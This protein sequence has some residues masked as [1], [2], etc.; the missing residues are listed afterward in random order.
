MSRLGVRKRGRRAQGLA[1]SGWG[2]EVWC[3]D[4]AMGASVGA[5]H[6]PACSFEKQT[7]EDNDD[8]K[9]DLRKHRPV[10]DI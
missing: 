1:L 6:P 4:I 8:E 5:L 3:L 2:V 7:Y 9:V 10:A